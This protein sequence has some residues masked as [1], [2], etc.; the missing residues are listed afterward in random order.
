M[1]SGVQYIRIDGGNTTSLFIYLSGDAMPSI[2]FKS[3]T[4][5]FSIS[6]AIIFTIYTASFVKLRNL[7]KIAQTS[8]TNKSFS[9]KTQQ[10]LAIYGF[11]MTVVL[12]FIC[13]FMTAFGTIELDITAYT[14]S[15]GLNIV[16]TL[17][18]CINPYLLIAMSSVLRRKFIN[19]VKEI[20][21]CSKAHVSPAASNQSKSLNPPEI[22]LH[23]T[24]LT[25][26]N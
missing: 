18:D 20:T 17:Y 22:R 12:L 3:F 2:Y 1:L 16:N 9:N 8:S 26:R 4:A 10:T 21:L 14:F 23:G 19:L 6:S 11:I 25:M 13:A 15:Y 7:A 24:L 5:I